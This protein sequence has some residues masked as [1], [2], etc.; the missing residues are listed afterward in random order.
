MGFANVPASRASREV[1]RLAETLRGT[2]SSEALFRLPRRGKT[3]IPA[4]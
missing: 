1:A 2:R 3:A 4:P